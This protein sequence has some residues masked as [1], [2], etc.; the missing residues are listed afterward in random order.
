MGR[1]P[2]TPAALARGALRVGMFFEHSQVSSASGEVATRTVLSG[3][4]RMGRSRSEGAYNE[5][6]KLM[7]SHVMEQRSFQRG[8]ACRCL[9]REEQEVCDR[10]WGARLGV[11]E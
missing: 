10:S 6:L 5:R 8:K 11:E 3:I 7:P 9:G 1:T 2:G 4:T